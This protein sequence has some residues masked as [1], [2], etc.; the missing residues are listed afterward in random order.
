MP[1]SND[2][3]PT[4]IQQPCELRFCRLLSTSPGSYIIYRQGL[5]TPDDG[6][7]LSPAQT[8]SVQREENGFLIK[9]RPH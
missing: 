7:L 4:N 6:D 2:D 1:T 8:F 9:W 5:I 3:G